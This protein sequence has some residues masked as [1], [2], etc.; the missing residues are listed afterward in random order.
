MC[1][2]SNIAVCLREL[3]QVLSYYL[4]AFSGALNGMWW[5][6]PFLRT[7]CEVE[8]RE[9]RRD[10]HPRDALVAVGIVGFT[11]TGPDLYFSPEWGRAKNG[12]EG[13]YGSLDGARHGR[14]HDEI[15]D[16]RDLDLLSGFL[17]CVCQG[18]VAMRVAVVD[19]MERLSMA[20][21]VD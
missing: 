5:M 3:F 20:D 11:Q 4:C 10:F 7:L 19:I 13:I 9:F 2:E 12:W 18:R 15:W 21:D 8:L 16:G 17:S 14:D 1:D 6:I